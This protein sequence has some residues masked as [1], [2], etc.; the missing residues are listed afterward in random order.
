MIG[1]WNKK[2]IRVLKHTHKVQV[3]KHTHILSTSTDTESD[4]KGELT[5]ALEY[6]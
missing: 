6:A 4:R 5:L 1:E 2:M 3:L